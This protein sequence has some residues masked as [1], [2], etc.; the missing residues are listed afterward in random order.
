MSEAYEEHERLSELRLGR[1][2]DGVFVVCVHWLLANLGL[3]DAH[4][5][6]GAQT[7]CQARGNRGK[8]ARSQLTRSAETKRVSPVLARAHS[9]YLTLS[10]SNAQQRQTE[11][12]DGKDR[13]QASR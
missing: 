3:G 4:V 6:A 8:S 11:S 12:Y 13:C 10:P 2:H 7:F 1:E 5:P 9:S